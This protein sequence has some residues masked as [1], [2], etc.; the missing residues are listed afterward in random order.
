M[1]INSR[2][3]GQRGERQVRDLLQEVVDRA[4]AD[5]GHRFPPEVKRNLMQSREGGCDLTGVPGVAVEVKFQEAEHLKQWW[6]Q[7]LDQA[8]RI[9]A[10]PVLIWRRARSQWQAMMISHLPCGNTFYPCVSILSLDDLLEWLYGH[11]IH[12]YTIQD[13]NV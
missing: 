6:A 9:D 10:V 1:R 7:T 4:A 2:S 12:H 5:C 13:K 3:K 11:M 8:A